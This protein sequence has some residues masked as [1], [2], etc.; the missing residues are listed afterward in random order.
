MNFRKF[1]REDFGGR[2]SDRLKR[3]VIKYRKVWK[4]RSC[5]VQ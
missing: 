5:I 3:K 4:R 2:G 1:R